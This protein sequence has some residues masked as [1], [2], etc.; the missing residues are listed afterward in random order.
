MVKGS[1]TILSN[2]SLGM[3]MFSLG[4]FMALQPRIIACGASLALL[5]MLMHFLTGP[6]FMVITSIAAGLRGTVL[7]LSIVQIT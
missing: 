5:E 6:T 2:T 7:H 4:L 3:A 1:I